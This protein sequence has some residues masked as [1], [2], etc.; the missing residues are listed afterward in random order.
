MHTVVAVMDPSTGEHH[1]EVVDRDNVHWSSDWVP[2][3]APARID[4]DGVTYIGWPMYQHPLHS[5]SP[6]R[7]YRGEALEGVT[8]VYDRASET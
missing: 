5:G 3:N 4:V 8:L 1:L 2:F 6:Y 7:V